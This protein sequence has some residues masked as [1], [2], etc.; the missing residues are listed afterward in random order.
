MNIGEEIC[1]QWLRHIRHCEFVDYNL[2]IPDV[3]GEIDVIGLSMRQ[4][5]AYACEVACHL[6]TGLKYVKDKKPDNVPRLTAKFRKDVAYLSKTFPD[7]TRV[8]MLWSTVVKNQ[9]TGASH[10][11]MNDVKQIVETLKSEYQVQIETVVNHKFWEAL[12]ELRKIAGGT[13]EEMGS[14]VMRYLQVEH[15]LTKH[16]Q[17][18]GIKID[19]TASSI[20][21]AA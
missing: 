18:A 16:L 6:V 3:H 5:T 13:T 7:Y 12:R 10:N 2:K 1:G 11:Q 19:A 21:P 4:R 17:S 8:Y 15:F 9:K 20:L 14:S